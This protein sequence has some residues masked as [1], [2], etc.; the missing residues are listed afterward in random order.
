MKKDPSQLPDS[1]RL[2]VVGA[3]IV[4]CSAAYHLTRLGWR[5]IVVLEQGPLFET[6]GSTSHA[7]GGVFQTNFSRM[8]T[9][10]AKYTVRLYCDLDL[11]GQP[12]FHSVGGLEVALTPE[13]WTDLKRKAGVA[14]SWGV[15]A[16]LISPSEAR[17]L[18][19]ILDESTIRGAYHVPGD[20]IAQ[21]VRAA[22]AMARLSSASGAT[23]IE[24]TAVTAI[25]T[26][27]NRVGAVLTSRG[28]IATENV[29]VSAGI[30]GPR[31]GR[32]VGVAIPL[33]PV[34][35]QYAISAP[36][37]ELAGETREVVHPVLRHQDRAMYFRQHADCYGVGSYQH[38]PLLVDADDILDGVEAAGAPALMAFTPEHFESAHADAVELLPALRDV[39]LP[40][41]INGMFSFTP[42]GMPL[43]GESPDLGGFWV[44][45]AVWITHAGG[46][47]MAIAEWMDSGA[48]T[49]DLREADINRFPAHAVTPSYVRARGAQQ[50][51][52]VY[53]VIHPLQQM[54]NPREL[55]LSPFYPRQR[56]LGAVFFENAG[57]E[58]PQWFEANERLP[59]DPS[60]PSRSGWA[61]RHWSPIQGCEH[62]GSREHVSLYDLSPLG[63]IEVTGS[64]AADFVHYMTANR[65]DETVGKVT[66]TTM[67]NE[68]GGI[69]CDVTVLPLGRERF[70]VFTGG[71]TVAG[72]L[73]WLRQQAPAPTGGPVQLAEV[74][75][76]FCGLGLWGPRAREVLQRVCASDLSN[77]AFPYFTARQ[78]ELELIP[79][80]ALRISYVG[81]LGW[82][83]YTRTEYALRLWDLLW[84]A[85]QAAGIVA[86]GSGAFDSLRLEKGYRLWGSDIHTEYNPFEAGLEWAVK[87]DKGDFQGRD[88]LLAIA[89]RG[90][91]RRLSCMIFDRVE[92]VILGKEPIL[93]G[94]RVLGYVTSTN[95]GYTVGRQIAYGYLPVEHAAEGTQ[96]EIEYFGDRFSAIVAAEPLYD[97][98]GTALCR[99]R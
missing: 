83:I 44:A 4:G 74:T 79:A 58:Q 30:W 13:R 6:G 84:E 26:E 11:D 93:A 36:L 92:A 78:I 81:E 99:R 55:R 24:S 70:L 12:C 29:L 97:P 91:S 59:R 18:V 73:A 76:Q 38:E 37:A 2:V 57:W 32:M 25:E 67:L 68:R 10:F 64:G 50:Y 71:G 7:P 27:G 42:N 54:E 40:Y 82:E 51:R 16:S 96:L 15:E 77:R 53:D 95:R 49:L 66:Y 89:E 14:K 72:D 45:E 43:I 3:G 75:S 39:D 61:A 20:G 8:M 34:Q 48:P 86:L 23:F 33:T 90:P 47:G 52:E 17:A 88:A 63:K 5:D 46:V 94:D 69:R 80:L 98:R 31:I 22:E 60:W 28:R 1:A 62:K 21:A 56:E 65:V 9:E 87:L 35:H 19:P 41:R 85:G